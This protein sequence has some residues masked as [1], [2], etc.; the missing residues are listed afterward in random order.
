[1]PDE[2]IRQD[3]GAAEAGGG[4]SSARGGVGDVELGD[5]DGEDFVRGFGDGALDD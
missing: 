5:S 1:M 4:P 2:V 3:N